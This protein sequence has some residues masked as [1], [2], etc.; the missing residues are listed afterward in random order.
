MLLELINY[1]EDNQL[2]LHFIKEIISPINMILEIGEQQLNQLLENILIQL[3]NN[4][5]IL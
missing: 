4:K 2:L 5:Y 3:T 1:A